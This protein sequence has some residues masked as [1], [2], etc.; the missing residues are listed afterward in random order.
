MALL[1]NR[2]ILPGIRSAWQAID[3]SAGYQ[4]ILEDTRWE[5]S[6]RYGIYYGEER[7]GDSITIIRPQEGSWTISNNIN[8]DRSLPSAL[9]GPFGGDA[10]ARAIGGIRAH[11]RVIVDD[12]Y[13]LVSISGW[14]RRSPGMETL[15]SI[16][17]RAVGN[18]LVVTLE[19][20]DGQSYSREISLD[21]HNIM[22]GGPGGLMNFPEP[23]VGRRWRSRV[24]HPLTMQM[25]TSNSKVVDLETINLE[26]ESTEAYRVETDWAGMKM[27]SYIDRMG[28][29][30]L[31]ETPMGIRLVRE[32][33]PEEEIENLYTPG[34]DE[35]DTTI[36]PEEL[37]L[38]NDD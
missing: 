20:A 8:L 35:E 7:L 36:P 24:L 11:T 12:D 6:R 32:R 17:G 22:A 30:L 29:L 2:E 9:L 27:V 38:T 15:V 13:R 3:I 23:Y 26:G 28:E 37:E 33:A 31:Q 5:R 16:D 18:K 21:T 34:V 4:P 25:E 14:V 19:D 1:I 10:V